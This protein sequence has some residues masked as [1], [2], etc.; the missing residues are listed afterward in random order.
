M[1]DRV[2]HR[3]ADE[4]AH[5]TIERRRGLRERLELVQAWRRRGERRGALERVSVG[6]LADGER[7]KLEAAALGLKQA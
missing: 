6:L 7:G 5:R 3:Q 2:A 1:T 4:A